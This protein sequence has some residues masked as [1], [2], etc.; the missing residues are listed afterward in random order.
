MANVLDAQH[1]VE[2]SI[3]N[4]ESLGRA[5]PF[6]ELPKPGEARLPLM[7]ASLITSL[8]KRPGKGVASPERKV[9]L[10]HQA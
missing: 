3:P 1:A 8:A 10:N 7:W 2:A 4:G 9:L 5:W 6:M